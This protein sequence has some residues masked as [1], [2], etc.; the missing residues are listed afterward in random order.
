MLGMQSVLSILTLAL[1]ALS[2]RGIT[3]ERTASGAGHRLVDM[4][5]PDGDWF[6]EEI[7][8]LF[9]EIFECLEI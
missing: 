3:M 1:I 7:C 4:T 6:L 8:G 2:Q 9:G 5:S